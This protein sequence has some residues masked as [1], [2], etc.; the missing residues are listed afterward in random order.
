[1]DDDGEK[2]SEAGRLLCTFDDA[3]FLNIARMESALETFGRYFRLLA[4]KENSCKASSLL[5]QSLPWLDEVLWGER[6]SFVHGDCGTELAL[7]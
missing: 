1:M 3:K 2:I 6:M 7:N 4:F 5:D